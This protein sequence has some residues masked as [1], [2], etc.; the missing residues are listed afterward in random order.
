MSLDLSWVGQVDLQPSA[1]SGPAST[2]QQ[3]HSHCSDHKDRS[4]AI[5]PTSQATAPQPLLSRIQTYSV[6]S[7]PTSSHSFTVVALTMSSASSSF[8]GDCHKIK[9]NTF[10]NLWQSQVLFAE[11]TFLKYTDKEKNSTKFLIYISLHS[12]YSFFFNILL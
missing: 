12:F 6:N 8:T 5:H 7:S 3:R 2:P 4:T 11:M 10:Q 1:S 9:Q